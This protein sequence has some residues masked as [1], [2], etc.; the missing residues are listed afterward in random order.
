MKANTSCVLQ[1]YVSGVSESTPLFARVCSEF[2]SQ[3]ATVPAP[4]AELIANANYKCGNNGVF[5]FKLFYSLVGRYPCVILWP[6]KS[7]SRNV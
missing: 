5:V 6:N 1:G 7:C 4:T 2:G 3:D